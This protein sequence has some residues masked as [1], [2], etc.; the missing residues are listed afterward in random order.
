MRTIQVNKTFNVPDGGICNYRH[1]GTF[2]VTKQVCNFCV[3]QKGAKYCA[4]FNMRPLSTHGIEVHKCG[5]CMGTESVEAPP[6]PEPIKINMPQLVG[7]ICKELM[8]LRKQLNAQ[9]LPDSLA[10]PQAISHLKNKY[11]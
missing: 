6:E 5:A 3:T 11:K 7:T 10:L 9:G 2:D 4:L 8:D 1:S